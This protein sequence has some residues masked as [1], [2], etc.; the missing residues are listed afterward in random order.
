M[1][2]VVRNNSP[3]DYEKCNQTISV[4]HLN[5]STVVKTVI[6]GVFFDFKKNQSIEKTGSSEVNSFLL[7]I[8]KKNY[9]GVSSPIYPGDKVVLGSTQTIAD[10]T[11]WS[12]AIPSKVES[13]VVVKYVDPKYWNGAIAHWEAGG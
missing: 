12:Q 9:S 10:T 8:P 5:G 13:L 2:A 4:F 7:V 6:N 11:A 3:V 1:L